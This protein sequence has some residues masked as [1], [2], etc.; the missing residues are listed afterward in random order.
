MDYQ[1]IIFAA[2]DRLEATDDEKAALR[3]TDWGGFEEEIEA[4]ADKAARARLIVLREEEEANEYEIRHAEQIRQ[5][6]ERVEARAV[7]S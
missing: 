6:T 1:D 7:R 5:S 4:D 2:I 3:F